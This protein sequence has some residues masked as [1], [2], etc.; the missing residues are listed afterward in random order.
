MIFQL[1]CNCR[2][3]HLEEASTGKTDGTKTGKSKA[4]NLIENLFKIF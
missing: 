4:P 1:S 3:D 2:L